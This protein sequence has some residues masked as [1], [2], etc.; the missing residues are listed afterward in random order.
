MKILFEHDH[1]YYLPQFEPV[2]QKLK[3][4]GKHDLFG[5]LNVSVPKI[6]RNLFSFEMERLGIENVPG[7]FKKCWCFFF[8]DRCENMLRLVCAYR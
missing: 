7:N 8:I 2:I 4:M 3:L 6:E 1:L 5:S